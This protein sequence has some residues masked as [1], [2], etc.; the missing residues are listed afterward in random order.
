MNSDIT[1]HISRYPTSEWIALDA[2]SHYSGLGRGVADGS[3]WDE[4]AWVGR[5]AQTLFLD[6]V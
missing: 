6:R 4:Y 5:S 2:E 3:L 1:A